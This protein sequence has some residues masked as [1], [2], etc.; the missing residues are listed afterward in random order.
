MEDGGPEVSEWN[1]IM[2]PYLGVSWLDTPWLYSE[3]YAYRRVMEAFSFFKTGKKGTLCT[4]THTFF[5]HRG[6]QV[7][8]YVLS[9]QTWYRRCLAS[10]RLRTIVWLNFSAVFLLQY[11]LP[12]QARRT[13]CARPTN[14]SVPYVWAVIFAREPF[15]VPDMFSDCAAAAFFGANRV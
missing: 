9:L 14:S 4:E 8:G 2:E 1:A 10:G 12:K 7:C 11:R 15:T 6:V 3:F 5:T 13:C